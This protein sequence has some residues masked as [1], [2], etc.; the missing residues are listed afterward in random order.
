MAKKYPVRN[1]IIFAS[2]MLALIAFIGCETSDE[3]KRSAGINTGDS[4]NNDLKAEATR[5]ILEGLSNSNPQ[6]RVNAI[7]IAAA[8]NN[9]PFMTGVQRLTTD[10]FVLIRFAAAVAIGDAKYYA[11]KNDVTQMLKDKDENVRM[12]ADYAIV[13]LGG[14]KSYIQQI[15][16]AL[17][18]NDQEIRANAAFLLGKMGDKHALPSLYQLIQDEAS[19]DRVRLNAIEA[20]ARLGDEKIYQKLWALLISAYAD[21]RA[22]GVQAMGALGTSR[23]KDSLLTILKDDVPEVRLTAAEQLGR[24]GDATGEKIVE[25]ALTHDILT[26]TDQESRA[27]IQTL[28]AMAIGQ[29]RTPALKKFLPELLKSDSHIAR[30]AAAKA[31]FLCEQ[32]NNAQ[33]SNNIGR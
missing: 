3:N 4:A 1:N 14:P 22:F 32:K 24:L 9:P 15:H 8:T 16:A 23:A 28:A 29:I 25:N 12:A 30:I 20:I 31:V 6:I 7:E 26:A 21:D 2:V 11:G 13:M 10:E 19:D 5:I 27:R 18:G 17:A 33:K